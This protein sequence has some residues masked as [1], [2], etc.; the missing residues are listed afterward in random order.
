VL[1]FSNEKRVGLI[2]WAAA[3]PLLIS[4]RLLIHII[5]IFIVS[6]LSHVFTTIKTGV[7][8]CDQR[9]RDEGTG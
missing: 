2:R 6:I 9:S 8:V 7:F 5:C 3:K 1:L 4:N